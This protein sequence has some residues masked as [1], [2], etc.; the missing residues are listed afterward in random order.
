[1]DLFCTPIWVQVYD[2]PMGY[3]SEA[4][5]QEIGKR[6]GGFIDCDMRSFT[7]G[8]SEYLRI[9]IHKDIRKPLQKVGKIKCNQGTG[10]A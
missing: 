5:G 3:K 2:L 4:V 7:S 8:W 9:Q 10:F 1:M 6:M